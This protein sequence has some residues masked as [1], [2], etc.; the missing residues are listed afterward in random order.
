MKAKQCLLLYESI[1]HR[2]GRLWQLPGSGPS[3]AS[4]VRLP[5]AKSI[6]LLPAS[7]SAYGRAEGRAELARNDRNL[8]RCP[9]LL[10]G[11]SDISVCTI[12]STD[13]QYRGKYRQLLALSVVC[14][15]Q[16]CSITQ[17]FQGYGYWLFQVTKL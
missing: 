3:T 8:H 7:V 6:G 14:Y 5:F 4:D 13:H 12:D 16:C 9:P 17:F 11:G 1:F 2:A 15:F 10:L